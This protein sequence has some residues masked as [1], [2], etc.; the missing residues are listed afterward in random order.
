MT[1]LLAQD[2]DNVYLLWGFILVAGALALL[3]IEL[4][5]PS[6]GLIGALAGVA[7]IGSIAAFFQYDTLW[8]VVATGAYVVLTPITLVFIFKVWIHSPIGR[9]MILGGSDPT[10]TDVS[11]EHAAASEYAR[12]ERLA[13]LRELIGADGVTATALRPVG[14]VVIQ[15]ERIDALAESGVI[16]A[17]TPVVVTDVYDNQIKVRPK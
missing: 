11:D 5:V 14:T 2:A 16:E 9:S 7:A 13:R 17:G 12:V 6:G 3:V 15:N 8:G 10:A 4:F 1:T